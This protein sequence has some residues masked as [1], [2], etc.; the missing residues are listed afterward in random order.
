MKRVFEFRPVCRRSFPNPK[1]RVGDGLAVTR[2]RHVRDAKTCHMPTFQDLSC[3]STSTQRY[4]VELPCSRESIPASCR[5]LFL[6]WVI[7]LRRDQ[8]RVDDQ[9]GYSLRCS[10]VLIVMVFRASQCIDRK[11]YD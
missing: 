11:G 8:G 5:T 2:P 3:D 9:A 1:N 4:L 7:S 10:T 6:K